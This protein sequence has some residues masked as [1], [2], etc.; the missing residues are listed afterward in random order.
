MQDTHYAEILT[1]YS[2]FE[3]EDLWGHSFIK[4]KINVPCKEVGSASVF[5][6]AFITCKIQQLF[7]VEAF[8]CAVCL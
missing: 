4:N 6:I 7:Q 8:V 1:V 5:V 2:D 3:A